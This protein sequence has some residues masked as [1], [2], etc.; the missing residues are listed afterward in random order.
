VMCLVRLRLMGG[1]V[2]AVAFALVELSQDGDAGATMTTAA[3]ESALSA[4]CRRA[5]SR[6]DIRVLVLLAGGG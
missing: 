5:S 3:E 2:V 1:L 4:E 6:Q